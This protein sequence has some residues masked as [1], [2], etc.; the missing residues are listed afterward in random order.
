MHAIDPEDLSALLREL[1]SRVP[2]DAAALLARET[3]QRIEAALRQLPQDFAAGIAAHLPGMADEEPAFTTASTVRELM[4]PMVGVL[5]ADTTVAGAVDW[6][7]R[8]E[9]VSRITYL[10]VA[11]ADQRLLGMVVMRDLLLARPG[12]RLSE[13]MLHEPFAFAPDTEIGE[14]IRAA[15]NRHYPVYPVVDEDGYLLGLVRGWQLFERQAIEISAQSGTMVGLDKEERLSTPFWQS[16]RMR[17]PWLQVNLL[18]AFLAAM[19]VGAFED[20]ITRIVALAAFLPVLAGQSGNNGCQT[21][22]ITLRGLT[23]GELETLP[24]RSL[25]RKE[26]MMGALN[27]LLTG[28]IAAA[29]M[30]WFAGDTPDQRLALAAVIL[31]AMT[32]ACA[33]SGAFGVM[34]PLTLRRFGADPATASSIFLTTG[35]DIAGMGLMLLLATVLVL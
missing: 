14:A 27:G 11:S 21:L 8:S 30:W 16:F 28:L 13:V 6:L 33:L 7:A 23:L 32:G 26:V 12:Q 15:V 35:T 17:H 25:L 10:Y 19:V 24:V 34:V 9:E 1:R 29:A 2:V 20:T 22:A 3:P 5:P 31:I 18:T 4:E